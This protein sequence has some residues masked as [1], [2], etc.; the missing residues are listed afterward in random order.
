MS[1]RGNHPPAF[2]HPA[3]ARF[4]AV[5]R[6]MSFRFGSEISFFVLVVILATNVDPLFDFFPLFVFLCPVLLWTSHDLML[7]GY[8][9]ICK[10]RRIKIIS[11]RVSICSPMPAC[12]MPLESFRKILPS[13]ITGDQGR[14]MTSWPQTI[15]A[16]GG[17][18]GGGIIERRSKMNN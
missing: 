16:W 10:R 6:W 3:S 5:L 15:G 4:P 17:E 18:K 11:L 8:L 1:R 9:P 13:T 14:G 7:G 12:E 2:E